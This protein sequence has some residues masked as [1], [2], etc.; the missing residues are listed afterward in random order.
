MSTGDFHGG[1]TQ[2]GDFHV[3]G[4]G[5]FGGGDGYFILVFF[6]IEFFFETLPGISDD[7]TDEESN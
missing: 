1:D 3:S 7:L 5:F 2:I 4:G 6:T